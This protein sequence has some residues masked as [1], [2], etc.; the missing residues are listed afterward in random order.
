MKYSALIGN[1][2]EHSISPELFD[3]ISKK[4]GIEYAHLKITVE[5]KKE[6]KSITE[7]LIKLGS[8]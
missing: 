6:L 3:I 2:V 7:S 4:I 8:R 5:D 1:P